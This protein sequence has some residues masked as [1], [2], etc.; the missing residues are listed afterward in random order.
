MGN[1]G[2]QETLQRINEV[3]FQEGVQDNPE[4]AHPT[5]V[6]ASRA[7]VRFSPNQILHRRIGLLSPSVVSSSIFI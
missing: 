3:T 5:F 1:S 2:F 7:E 4:L 6:V